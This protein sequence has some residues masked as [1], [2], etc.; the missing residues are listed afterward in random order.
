MEGGSHGG[1]ALGVT[2]ASAPGFHGDYVPG[3]GTQTHWLGWAAT[4][5]GVQGDPPPSWARGASKAQLQLVGSP[6]TGT[7]N[8]SSCGPTQLPRRWG[9]ELT[10]P[11]RNRGL[12]TTKGGRAVVYGPSAIPYGGLAPA[13]QERHGLRG[14]PAAHLLETDQAERGKLA[15]LHVYLSCTF[16]G[17]SS[18]HSLHKPP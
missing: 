13:A 18:T 1:R 17:A 16:K 2:Q 5:W 8:I 9:L 12:G 10:D 7:P 3:T 6:C 15:N 4:R 14:G 11:S